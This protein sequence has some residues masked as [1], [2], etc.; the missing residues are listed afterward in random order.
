MPNQKGFSKVAIIIIVLILI[1]GAYF[2]FSKKDRKI[3]IQD[4]ENQNSQSNQS[5]SGNLP[6]NSAINPKDYSLVEYPIKDS[7]IDM[8]KCDYSDPNN[9]DVRLIKN[10][11]EVIAPSLIQIISAYKKE[12]DVCNMVIT[13]FSVPTEGRYLYLS[14]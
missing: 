3:S 11:N 2:V 1:G 8:T 13:V 4:T 6:K 14:S 10:G 5:S 7:P 9:K 12:L